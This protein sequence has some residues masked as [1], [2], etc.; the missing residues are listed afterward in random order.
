[1]VKNQFL[2]G[3][4]AFG[5]SLGICLLISPDVVRAFVTGLITVAATYIAVA[6]VTWQEQQRGGG[7]AVGLNHQI[8]VLLRRRAELHQTIADMTAEKDRV[9]Q[10]L[11]AMQ[12]QLRQPPTPT[13][14]TPAF[15]SRRAI[16]WD[17]SA[18]VEPGILIP[19]LPQLEPTSELPEAE[20]NQILVEAAESR[21]KIE[22]N[23]HWLQGEL[24]Q[25]NTQIAEQHQTRD[26]LNQ[27]IAALSQKHQQLTL[28][29]KIL[30]GEVD[31]LER[32]RKEL[33]QYLAYAEAKKRE[34]ETGANPLQG[35]LKQLQTQ[36]TALQTELAQLEDQVISHRREKEALE[37]Q[38]AVL[39]AEQ[40]SIEAVL[41]TQEVDRAAPKR[42]HPSAIA[43]DS[44]ATQVVQSSSAKKRDGN[45]KLDAATPASGKAMESSQSSSSGAVAT[46]VS[47]PVTQTVAQPSPAQSSQPSD[48]SNQT[49][50]ETWT[51]FLVQLPEYEL[52]VLRSL[53]QAGSAA[54]VIRKIAEDNL[55]TPEKLVASINDRAC[56]RLGHA[57][58]ELGPNGKPPTITRDYV[59]TVKKLIKTYDYLTE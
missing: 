38:I 31:D 40:L 47:Q 21:Q 49:L 25:L 19:P 55:T 42:Q 5:V 56:D 8:R 59:K 30:R 7:K 48:P 28:E 29:S 1:M 54:A 15:A 23:L 22:T 58:L 11:T 32:C 17:L 39:Q 18:P 43:P 36:I 2:L 27:E 9:A 45:G 14:P 53:T 13:V 46:V 3:S 44:S 37:Q 52:Q 34:L 41:A 26:R 57:I 20:V 35:A 50:S 33:E 4:I 12:L 6:I 51:E 24:S 16:S 10:A